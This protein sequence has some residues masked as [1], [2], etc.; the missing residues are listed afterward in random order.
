MPEKIPSLEN[1]RAWQPVLLN[2]AGWSDRNE[3]ACT[4][5]VLQ[6]P[7]KQYENTL[8]NERRLLQLSSVCVHAIA[9]ICLHEL[10]FGDAR[11]DI[12]FASVY[13]SAVGNGSGS[14]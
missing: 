11:R 14:E 6:C 3:K 1:T 7:P 12:P 5:E 13:L 10:V 9:T 2:A 8:N 4:A